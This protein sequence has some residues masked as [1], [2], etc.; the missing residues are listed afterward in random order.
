M[1][2]RYGVFLLTEEL[3]NLLWLHKSLLFVESFL[4]QVTIQP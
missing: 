4:E 2:D 1:H 3:L